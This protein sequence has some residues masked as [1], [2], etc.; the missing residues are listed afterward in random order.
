MRCVLVIWWVRLI[1]LRWLPLLQWIHAGS[2]LLVPAQP[3]LSPT[4]PQPQ[5]TNNGSFLP[6]AM[7]VVVVVL[8]IHVATNLPVDLLLIYHIL[9]IGR[10]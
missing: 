7:V 3:V 2:L 8:L 9:M 10:A 5:L 6:F 4:Q 1:L